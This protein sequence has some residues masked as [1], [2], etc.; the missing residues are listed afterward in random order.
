MQ[1]R[2]G[3]VAWLIIISAIVTFFLAWQYFG[4]RRA[5]RTLP[6]EMTMAGLSVE[7]MTREEALGALQGAFAM[8]VE[9][10]YREQRLPLY[11][12]SVELRFNI[13]ETVRNIID[14]KF[15][16]N[17]YHLLNEKIKNAE[18]LLFFTD[19]TGEI[20]F[21]KLLIDTIIRSKTTVNNKLKVTV[22][23]KGGPII[24]DATIED[25]KY[26]G[27][28]RIPSIDFK[29]ISN[30]DPNTGPERNSEEVENW[31]YNHDV[32]IAKGQGNYEEMHHYK[33]IFF[34]LMV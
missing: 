20:V 27:M 4:F 33:R 12:D 34:M 9:V 15:A 2:I 22:V 25:A 21:D 32:T 8:P 26:I 5:S 31:I 13:D 1:R 29:T 3:C 10:M 28:D 14:R 19:N 7:G 18:N 16:I 23:V 11:P 24:N 17:D 30:G 6:A